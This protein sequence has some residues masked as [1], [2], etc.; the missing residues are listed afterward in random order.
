[1][2]AR[3]AKIYERG[4][5]FDKEIAIYEKM[6][7]LDP[8]NASAMGRL[9][10]LYSSY[11]KDSRK[12]LELAKNA[13]NLASDDPL[14]SRVLARLVYEQRDFKWALS[15]YQEAAR[16][17]GKEP[18]LLAE[19]AW[20]Y[21]SM[22]RVEE[23]E[24]TMKSAV[25]TGSPFSKREEAKRFLAM[26]AAVKDTTQA[27]KIAAQVRETLKVEP[28]YLPALMISA[29]LQEQ[30]GQ[31]EQARGDYETILESNPLF[32]PATRNLALLWVRLGGDDKKVYDLTVKAREAFP[33]DPEVARALGIL[34]CRRGDAARGAQLLTEL[35]PARSDDAEL[36]YYL[37]MAQYQLKQPKESKQTL[38]RALA[39]NVEPKL[40]EQARR[41]LIE[42]K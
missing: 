9:A 12:A 3:L 18:E 1:V 10:Q 11:R 39:L 38:Q 26:V 40:A 41:V 28:K 42:L 29:L 23:A 24:S 13:H 25:E 7:K 22:G 32:T 17:L 31:Y 8:Q 2:A 34:A 30:A 5:S 27:G 21:Y 20:A 36:L 33:A 16:K 15:L 35:A 19:L 14:I 4:G 37:G 6:L